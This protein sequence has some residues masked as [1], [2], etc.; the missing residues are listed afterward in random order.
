[1]DFRRFRSLKLAFLVLSPFITATARQPQL[2]SAVAVLSRFLS[3]FLS[4]LLF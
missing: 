1:M 2:D 3:I 4:P